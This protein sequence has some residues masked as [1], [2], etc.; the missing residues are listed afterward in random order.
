MAASGL[1]LDPMAVEL[2]KPPLQQFMREHALAQA[3]IMRGDYSEGRFIILTPALNSSIHRICARYAEQLAPAVEGK[4]G[5]GVWPL[6]GLVDTPREH[7]DAGYADSLFRRYCD[8]SRIDAEIDA[9][10]PAKLAG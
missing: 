5:F 10:V 4:A 3:A 1:F 6:E 9:H 7:G 2:R 8:W